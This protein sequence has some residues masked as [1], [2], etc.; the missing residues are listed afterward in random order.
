MTSPAKAKGN[1]WELEL[2]RYL[3][4]TA[5]KPGSYLTNPLRPRQE[6]LEDSGDIHM[7]PFVIQA[8]N[9]A[10]LA[11]AM[12]NGVEGYQRQRKVA[13]MPFGVAMIKRRGKGPADGYA[14][15]SISDFMNV[16]DAVSFA[17]REDY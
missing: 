3:A 10:S 1:R 13:K 4:A 6:G 8:K 2:L 16:M 12:A 5:G 15:M 7:W 17:E 9:Y 11:D 14:V